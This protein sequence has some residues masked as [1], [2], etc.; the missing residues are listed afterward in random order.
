MHNTTKKTALALMAALFSFS[1]LFGGIIATD[2][3]VEGAE[4][5]ATG[6]IGNGIQRNVEWS[7]DS[8]FTLTV[9]GWSHS[10]ITPDPLIDYP[11]DR[12][13]GTD[14]GL[15]QMWN[16][17]GSP[18]G[19]FTMILEDQGDGTSIWVV[20]ALLPPPVTIIYTSPPQSDKSLPTTLINTSTNEEIEIGWT[21]YRTL[22]YNFFMTDPW[23][24]TYEENSTQFTVPVRELLI[25][26]ENT[27]LASI[28][29]VGNIMTLSQIT[30][31]STGS[32]F[33]ALDGETILEGADRAGKSY[34]VTQDEETTALYWQE[35]ER[36]T[37]SPTPTE[38]DNSMLWAVF[39]LCIFG[40]IIGLALAAV[41]NLPLG[42]VSAII[43]A[44]GAILTYMVI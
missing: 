32:R 44:I 41:G 28:G 18:M 37:E 4:V 15:Y 29:A 6:T 7:L 16:F 13:W 10:V 8:D 43:A 42:I 27:F 11:F 12:A 9:T 23:Q 35:I 14:T 1:F 5:I 3:T 36:A 33:V 38:S 20:R 39:A 25:D 2:N 17:D 31:N 34:I 40:V 26:T 22:A 19:M 21:N 30:I 24:I